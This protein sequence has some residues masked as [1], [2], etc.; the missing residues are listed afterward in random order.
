MPTRQLP[1]RP[2]LT[3]LKLQAKELRRAHAES[4]RSAAARILAHHPRHRG[5]SLDALLASPFSVADAQLV[6]AREYGLASWPQLKHR[7]ELADRITRFPPHPQFTEAL[8]AFDAGDIERLRFLLTSHTDLTHART[9]LEPPYD[10][11]SAA[12]LLH[13]IAGNPR[14]DASLPPN[15][16]DIAR[17]LLEAGS[18]V[19]AETIGPNGGTTMGL[20][21]TSKQAS[22]RG[23]TGSLMDLLLEYGATLDLDA[24]DALDASLANHAPAAAEKMVELGARPDVLA[25]AALGNLDRLRGCFDAD[26]RLRIRPRRNGSLMT[27]ADAIGL[28]LLYAYVREQRDAVEFLLEKDGNWNMTGVNNGTAL[29]RAAYAGDLAMVQKLVAKGADVSNREN[30]F[31]STPLSW[32]AH[33][34]Q[35]AVFDWLVANCAID[36]HEAVCYDLRDHIEARLREDPSSVNR[37]LDQWE[38]PQSTPL[39][40][41]AWLYYDDVAGTHAHDATSRRQLVELLL[42]HEADP[43]IVAGNGLTPLDI[44]ERSS[45]PGIVALLERRGGKRAA[46][47]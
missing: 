44:A 19:H 37:L 21:V 18:D 24:P 1:P 43:N 34:R 10:Y 32:A 13:H 47:L 3:Q 33:A 20:L 38:I 26:G 42:D 40:W 35:P 9:N 29:H 28:A 14:R 41:A 6:I 5:Q 45:A 7:V 25:A 39:H 8:A 11:F 17:L 2:S 46:E 15:V 22:D 23:V 16:I 36:L 27:E 12:T 30:P 4:D 31:N